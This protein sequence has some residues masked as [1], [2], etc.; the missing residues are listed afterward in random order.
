MNAHTQ[1]LSASATLASRA[2]VVSLSISQWSGRRLDREITNE[3]NESHN[4]AADAGRYNKLLLPKEAL[5]P[6]NKVVSETRQGFLERTLPWM[7]GGSRIMNAGAFLQHSAWMRGQQSKFTAAVEKFLADYPGHVQAAQ[8][9]LNGMFK[10]EDYPSVEEL[11]RKFGMDTKVMPVPTSDDFRVAMSEEQ[12]A[13]IKADIERNVTNATQ[14]AVRDVYRRVAE[15]AE[16]MVDRLTKFKPATKRGQKT[17]GVFRDSLVE[18]VRDLIMILPS[19]NITGDP[20]LTALTDRLR[21]LA[22]WD[23][24][25]LRENE[26]VRK[27]V[28]FEAQQILD[29]VSDFLA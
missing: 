1:I 25:V 7:D 4:A 18:N 19:L 21:P 12:A 16:R 29:Q 23:A 8:R 24:K 27:D 2:I 11:R 15:V 13:R 3:V 22:E 9:R 10:Q 5:E 6:I 26:A 14:E 17:E 20:E 28:A